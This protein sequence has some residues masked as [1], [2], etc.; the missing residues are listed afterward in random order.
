M[1]AQRRFKKAACADTQS[2]QSL[3]FLHEETLHVWLSKL[4][5]VNIMISL[6]ECVGWE[7][8]LGAHAQRYLFWRCSL[9]FRDVTQQYHTGNCVVSSRN[10]LRFFFLQYYAHFSSCLCFLL[11]QCLMLCME[12]I[13]LT[14]WYMY[15]TSS[16]DKHEHHYLRQNKV[17]EAI[18]VNCTFLGLYIVFLHVLITFYYYCYYYYYYYYI[19]TWRGLG[20]GGGGGGLG[21]CYQ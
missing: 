13:S 10:S 14:I 3:C 11:F 1:C 6:W 20:E 19:W 12:I 2:D 5:P 7:S 18:L 17:R 15:R 4:C 9:Y 8:L 21:A 16:C